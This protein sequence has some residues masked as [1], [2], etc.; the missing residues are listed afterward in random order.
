MN[1][2]IFFF[3]LFKEHVDVRARM[4][5]IRWCTMIHPFEGLAA[6]RLDKVMTSVHLNPS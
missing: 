6:S 3:P 1:L 2:Q 5:G 4:T